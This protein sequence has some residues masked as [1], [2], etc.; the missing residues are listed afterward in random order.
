[1]TGKPTENCLIT[2]FNTMVFWTVTVQSLTKKSG[3]WLIYWIWML[4]IHWTYTTILN[5]LRPKLF[6]VNVQ[7]L[8]GSEQWIYD[9]FT[10]QIQPLE[11]I[12]SCN[13][14]KIE[15][16]WMQ[17]MSRCKRQYIDQHYSEIDFSGVLLVA[18]KTLKPWYQN[19]V[20][21]RLSKYHKIGVRSASTIQEFV[22]KVCSPVLIDFYKNSIDKRLWHSISLTKDQWCVCLFVVFQRN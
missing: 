20:I 16:S 6:A 8:Q 21:M 1:M 3:S 17:W 14:I 12:W 4:T 19:K 22:K 13:K 15:T 10:L 2:R 11:W 5:Q 7:Y 18:L 9:C